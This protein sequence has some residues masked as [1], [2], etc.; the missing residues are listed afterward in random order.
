[1][2]AGGERGGEERRKEGRRE[3]KRRGGERERGGEGGW[4]GREKEKNE[5]V[6]LFTPSPTFTNSHTH[7]PLCPGPA[8]SGKPSPI[9]ADPQT[10]SNVNKGVKEE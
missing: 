9:S 4:E 7:R 6:L 3:G 2:E 1:M 8:A 5:K 10:F